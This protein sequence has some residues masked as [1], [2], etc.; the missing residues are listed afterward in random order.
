MLQQKAHQV[1][2]GTSRRTM[3]RRHCHAAHS[4]S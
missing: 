4:R 3:L 1:D 2:A